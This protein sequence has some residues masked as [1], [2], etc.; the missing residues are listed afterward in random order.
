MLMIDDELFTD[1]WQHWQFTCVIWD[2]FL[3]QEM[4]ELESLC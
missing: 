4:S 2:Y 3:S 1:I